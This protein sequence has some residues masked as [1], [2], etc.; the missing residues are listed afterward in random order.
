M[1]Q[2]SLFFPVLYFI[3]LSSLRTTKQPNGKPDYTLK[4]QT[5]LF[6]VTL[7][8]FFKLEKVVL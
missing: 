2:V 6:S 3:L 8:C 1:P 4:M 5:L 7:Y